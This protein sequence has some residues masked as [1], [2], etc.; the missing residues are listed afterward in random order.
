MRQECGR[1]LKKRIL[2]FFPCRCQGEQRR[3]GALPPRPCALGWRGCNNALS[4]EVTEECHQLWLL[5]HYLKP[6]CPTLQTPLPAKCQ[7]S[8]AGDFLRGGG[9][10]SRLGRGWEGR[11]Y[12]E[13]GDC[14][15]VSGVPC[16]TFSCPK[17]TGE[18]F[19]FP[20][21]QI[22]FLLEVALFSQHSFPD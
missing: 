16:R 2:S 22:T 11:C 3:A 15:N 18:P 5:S 6:W 14:L 19:S 1:K 8:H 10:E 21:L 7:L 13:G 17:T 4:P 12:R 9:G 20:W